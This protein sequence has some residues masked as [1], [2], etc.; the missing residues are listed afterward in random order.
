MTNRRHVPLGSVAAVVRQTVD[1]RVVPSDT[2]Y[3]GLEN[4]QPGGALVG[5]AAARHANLASTKF[6]FS[7]SDVLYGKL[8]PYLAKVATPTFNGI[9]STDIL[10]LRPGPNLH[11]DYLAHYLRKPDIV[12]LAARLATG[13]N[14]P[15]LSQQ[16]LEEFRLP[17][18][19]LYEQRYI[20]EILDSANAIRATRQRV[21]S[22][23]D[24][25]PW[26]LFQEM[27]GTE[28]TASLR[29]PVAPLSEVLKRVE[30]GRS[31]ANASSNGSVGPYR[32]LR[33]SSVTSNRFRSNESRPVPA[34]YHP[35][36]RDHFV[37]HGDLLFSRANTTQLV[38]AVAL[39]ESPP[40]NLLL[41]DKIWR[42]VWHDSEALTPEFMWQLLRSPDVRHA[43]S[44]RATGTSGSMKNI[45]AAKL[46]SVPIIRPPQTLEQEYGRRYRAILTLRDKA[47]AH[48]CLLDKL[49]ASLQSRAFKGE[50]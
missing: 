25:L 39:V 21:L 6:Q 26:F 49:F 19:D 13:A 16:R 7:S 37:R 31:V 10:P 2:A 24:R 17:L 28:T 35:P 43:L 22:A 12:A 45:S 48:H 23:L 15:R 29:W 14:L 8:R 20:A 3:I 36:S 32:V 11:R 9:C 1:P 44:Q 5:V 33:V 4:I 50:L 27:F 46:L 40:A 42:L 47:E 41:P 30:G 34:K 18:P 38:G